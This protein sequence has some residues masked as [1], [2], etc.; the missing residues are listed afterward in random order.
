MVALSSIHFK[1]TDRQLIDTIRSLIEG[2]NALPNP[3]SD[4]LPLRLQTSIR[5]ADLNSPAKA[6]L[7]DWLY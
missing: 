3:P 2:E 6:S 5:K 7:E 4:G 1:L